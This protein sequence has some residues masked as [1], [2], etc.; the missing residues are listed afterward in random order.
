MIHL[1]ATDINGRLSQALTGGLI[2]PVFQPILSLRNRAL[3]AFEVL[4]RW[5]DEDL[6]PIGPTEF[7]PLVERAGLLDQLTERTI[8]TA[9]EFAAGWPGTFALAFNVSPTQLLNPDL[10][11]LIAGAAAPSGFPLSR[12]HIEITENAILAD[13]VAVRLMVT[14]L[15]AMGLGIVL[16]DFGTGYSSLTRLQSLPFTKIKIDASFVRTMLKQRQSRKIVTAVVGLGESLG[17]PIVAEGVET[18]AQ[19]ALLLRIGCDLGQGWLFGAGIPGADVPAAMTAIGERPATV[20]SPDLSLEQRSAQLE[21]IYNNSGVAIGFIDPGRRYVSVNDTFAQRLGLSIADIVGRYVHEILPDVQE[22]GGVSWE[23]LQTG[24]V[25]P[26]FEF[27]MDHGSDLVSLQPVPDEAGDLLGFSFV[28]IDISARMRAEAALR[29]SLE[30]YRYTVELSPQMSWTAAPDGRLLYM[31]PRFLSLIGL[32]LEQLQSGGRSSVVHP[33]ERAQ[34]C[35]RWTECLA[36]G[37]VHT[38]QFR[39]R[40]ADGA[41]RRMRTYAAPRLD[42]D[43]KIVRWYG[44]LADVDEPEIA[45]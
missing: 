13:E 7:I 33:E 15:K 12:I 45:S 28:A 30:N 42:D 16:D 44:S 38:M 35:A 4:S 25:N 23:K 39:V 2:T 20:R 1:S 14:R 26:A 24:Q 19:A 43:G 11:D 10:P 8:R 27:R 22:A 9:C 6:G 32:T 5:H 18:E 40:L 31:S 36:S 3:Y 29:E 41:Y 21:A 34:A 17:L 37:E